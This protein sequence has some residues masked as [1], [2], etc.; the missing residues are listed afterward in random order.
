MAAARHSL[1]S[2]RDGAKDV[3]DYVRDGYLPEAL[4]SFIARSL[5]YATIA[6][7]AA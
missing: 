2:K 1:L 5:R 3:L 7:I 6:F 4:V